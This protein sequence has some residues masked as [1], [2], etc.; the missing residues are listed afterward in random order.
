MKGASGAGLVGYAEG[1]YPV[2][3]LRQQVIEPL[4]QFL[5]CRRRR[6]R[7]STGNFPRGRWNQSGSDRDRDRRF[8]REGIGL[9]SG[10]S[11]GQAKAVINGGAGT[12]ESEL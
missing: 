5:V 4:L 2:R 11:G 10:G 6:H 1:S 8:F 3:L 7:G 12:G 9:R